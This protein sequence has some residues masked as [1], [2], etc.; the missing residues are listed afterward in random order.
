MIP[1]N[2]VRAERLRRGMTQFDLAIKTRISQTDI[3][4]IELGK[5]PVFPKWRRKLS[6]AL[7][8]PEEKLFPEVHANELSRAS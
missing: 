3:C 6:E 4:Q 2:N 8:V 5:R 1:S 7:G